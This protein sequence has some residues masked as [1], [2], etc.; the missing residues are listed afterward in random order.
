[1]K[2]E[3]LPV[4]MQ[5]RMGVEGSRGATKGY[6]V[7]TTNC[8]M[9]DACLMG[10]CNGSCCCTCTQESQNQHIEG[11]PHKKIITFLPP[12]SSNAVVCIQ[13]LIL[14]GVQLVATH[15]NRRSGFKAQVSVMHNIF[16]HSNQAGEQL[17]QTRA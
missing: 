7:T 2:H 6:G 8:T 5:M 13:Y 15:I 3:G 1:V 14:W 12:D 4:E 10:H 17:A 16:W 9:P 11:H